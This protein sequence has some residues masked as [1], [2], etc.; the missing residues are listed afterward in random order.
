LLP[1]ELLFQRD[2]PYDPEDSGR[3]K[4]EASS[5][6]KLGVTHGESDEFDIKLLDMYT[7]I[8]TMRQD[9]E[10][11]KKPI[12]TKENPARTCKDLYYGHPKFKDGW[13]WIDPNMGM[14][15]DAV[16]VF[17]NM[18]V[19][20]ETCVFPDVRSS[21]I[22]NIPWRR[23]SKG[24]DA[25]FSELRGGFTITYETTGV[26]QM[27]FLRLL[28]SYAYQN[29]T[30]SCVQSKAWFDE[31]NLNHD[32]AIKFQGQDEHIFSI[33]TIK[34]NVLIDGCA[35]GRG[36]PT[37]KARTVFEVRTDKLS[38][39]P[40]VDFQPKDYGMPNQ[41]FGFEAGPVCFK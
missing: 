1:P 35:G 23:T 11:L 25:W 30:Y 20:G 36:V 33:D 6:K 13:Y 37:D 34:P 31:D 15:D 5:G 8:Y 14:P 9:L 4:R 40:L 39:L 17:C 10:R 18:T 22:I 16:Y 38:Q 21:K 41:A 7:N 3:F 12:G 24:D 28:S 32:K 2:A 29:F 27:T 26:V 19:A